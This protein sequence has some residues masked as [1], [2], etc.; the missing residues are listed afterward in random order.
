M[1]SPKQIILL[2]MFIVTVFKILKSFSFYSNTNIVTVSIIKFRFIF[3]K[4]IFL[5][6]NNLYMI[7]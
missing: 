4:I 2:I 7:R 1:T 6:N 5:L 3:L